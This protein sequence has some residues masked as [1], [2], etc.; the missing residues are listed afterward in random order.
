MPTPTVPARPSL[1][2]VKQHDPNQREEERVH[3]FFYFQVTVYRGGKLD[4]DFRQ[5]PEA[6]TEAKTMGKCCLLACQRSKGKQAKSNV[7]FLGAFL[8]GAPPESAT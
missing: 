7:F 8:S 2:V 3:V 6:G 5:E 4:A 1:A